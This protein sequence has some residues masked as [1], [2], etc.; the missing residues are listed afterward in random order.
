MFKRIVGFVGLGGRVYLVQVF[1]AEGFLIN[2]L[3]LNFRKM[4]KKI[5]L[6]IGIIG[7]FAVSQA[8]AAWRYEMQRESCNR[9]E[10]ATFYVCRPTLLY[11]GCSVEAQ[12]LCP[13][14]GSPS[15]GE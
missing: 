10:G 14:Y 5:I 9:V 2:R 1:G 8:N 3:I 12:T 11:V 7:M 4:I 6:C 15:I 13:G